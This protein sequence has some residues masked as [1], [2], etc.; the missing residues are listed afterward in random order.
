MNKELELVLF[1]KMAMSKYIN[2]SYLPTNG[3]GQRR[4]DEE[5]AEKALKGFKGRR[6]TY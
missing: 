4:R 3:G 6:L 2:N 5:R 1:R